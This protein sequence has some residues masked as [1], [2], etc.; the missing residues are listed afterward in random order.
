MFLKK[1]TI[2]NVAM[3]IKSRKKKILIFT[4]FSGVTIILLGLFL[5][6]FSWAFLLP[7]YSQYLAT[8][9]LIG[10]ILFVTG[11]GIAV[12]PVVYYLYS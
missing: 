11:I 6:F 9:I 10:F 4:F 1:F 7:L 12:L 8:S 3:T 5:M 2:N